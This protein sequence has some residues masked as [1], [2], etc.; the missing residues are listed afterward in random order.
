MFAFQITKHVKGQLDAVN[1]FSFDKTYANDSFQQEFNI[2]KSK[3]ISWSIKYMWL[4]FS[5]IIYC[6][7]IKQKYYL[8][9]RVIKGI[10]GR[11]LDD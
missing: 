2:V 9:T 8:I 1:G 6:I 7:L 5:H 4:S 3:L 11:N 10:N